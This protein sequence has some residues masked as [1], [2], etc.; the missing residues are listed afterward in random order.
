LE[1]AYLDRGTRLA[2]A[3][4][5][6]GGFSVASSQKKPLIHWLM[7][8][9]RNNDRKWGYTGFTPF[10]HLQ[11]H[12]KEGDARSFSASGVQTIGKTVKAPPWYLILGVAYISL[13]VQQA[14]LLDIW[15]PIKTMHCTLVKHGNNASN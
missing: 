13:V 6:F 1:I 3:Q 10:I 5:G 7:S 11:T 9:S 12:L 15:V 8:I 14:Q 4:R 2:A